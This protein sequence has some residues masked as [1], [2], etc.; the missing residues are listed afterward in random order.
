MFFLLET[1]TAS[2]SLR[3]H[4]L[5]KSTCFWWFLDHLLWVRQCSIK[6]HDYFHSNLTKLLLISIENELSCDKHPPSSASG[7]PGPWFAGDAA[8]H[9]FP[10][11]CFF[12]CTV[13]HGQMR[14]DC[15]IIWEYPLV[16]CYIAIENGHRNSGFSHLRWWFSSSLC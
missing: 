6:P 8:M 13:H 5:Q 4:V 16:I 12:R 7:G 1:I 15:C 9:E 3:K 10:E 11:R 2:V 14:H